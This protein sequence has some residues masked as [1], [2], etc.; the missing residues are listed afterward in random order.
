MEA[1]ERGHIRRPIILPKF[2]AGK[3]IHFYHLNNDFQFEPIKLLSK[4]QLLLA[5]DD[6][7]KQQTYIQGKNV[8]LFMSANEVRVISKLQSQYD[9]KTSRQ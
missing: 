7:G 8:S 9:E 1:N 3:T 4:T 5:K 6:F 2:A